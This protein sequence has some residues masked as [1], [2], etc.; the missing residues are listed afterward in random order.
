VRRAG[1][2]ALR[3]Q[4]VSLPTARPAPAAAPRFAPSGRGE[5]AVGTEGKPSAVPAAAPWASSPG[6]RGPAL[7]HSPSG[8]SL[9]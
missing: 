8:R 6:Q 1:R 2:V 7:S 3:Q 9:L 5:D 4:I